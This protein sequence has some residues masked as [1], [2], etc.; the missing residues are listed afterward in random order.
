MALLI[1]G[2]STCPLCG[3]VISATADVV[4]TPAFLRSSHELSRFSDAVFHRECFD[5]APERVTV[6]RL[7]REAKKTLPGGLTTLAE[8]ES[9]LASGSTATGLKMMPSRNQATDERS[10][11]KD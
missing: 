2:K 11:E 1:R 9:W 4:A 10:D 3:A 5:A 7:L 8:Y 6:E